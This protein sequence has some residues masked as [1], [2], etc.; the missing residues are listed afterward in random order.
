MK[1][2]IV[3]VLKWKN[4]KNTHEEIHEFDTVEDAKEYADFK[5]KLCRKYGYEFAIRIYKATND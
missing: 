2:Y 1:D 5:E 4:G 3:R